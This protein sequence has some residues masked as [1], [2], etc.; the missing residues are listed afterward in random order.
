MPNLVEEQ[1][2][3]IIVWNIDDACPFTR[4]THPVVD[5]LKNYRYL[6]SGVAND[7]LISSG[8]VD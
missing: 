7:S 2:E 4:E 6:D 8:S 5:N 1:S 3:R